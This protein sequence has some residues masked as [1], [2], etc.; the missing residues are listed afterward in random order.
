MLYSSIVALVT[1]FNEDFS[2]DWE[3]YEK[4]LSWHKEQGTKAVLVCGTTGEAPAITIE[5]KKQLWKKAKEIL[6]DNIPLIAGTGS[7]NTYDTVKLSEIAKECG[8]DFALVVTP[9]YNKPTDKGLFNHY[10]EIAK[11][12]IDIILYNV[13]SRTGTNIKVETV[14][15]IFE[16]GFI[17]A[18]KDAAGSTD[19]IV[20]LKNL[21]N[22]KLIVLSGDDN[23]YVPQLTCGVDGVI[24]V[25]ANIFPKQLA[26]IREKDKINWEKAI[27]FQKKYLK[28]MQLMFIET[29]PLPVKTLLAH[30]GKI[31]EVFRLP[32]AT[33]KEE[34]KKLLIN[35]FEQEFKGA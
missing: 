11:S 4:L 12:G 21:T 22:N 3:N 19:R 24:S 32:L 34:N 5:E 25:I 2:I 10:R 7:N 13:P 27:S 8:A 9:Y 17:K 16:A 1:P 28:L 6:G 20:Q 30:L 15:E 18:I 31:K 14:A 26:E 29:N 33:M 23:L 35:Y